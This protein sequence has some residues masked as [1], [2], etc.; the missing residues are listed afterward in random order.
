MSF[1]DPI[2]GNG[3]YEGAEMVVYREKGSWFHTT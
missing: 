3:Q 1:H 2:K